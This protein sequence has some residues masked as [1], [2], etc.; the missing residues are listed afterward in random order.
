MLLSRI[1]CSERNTTGPDY[2]QIAGYAPCRPGRGQKG[3]GGEKRWVSQVSQKTLWKFPASS[4]H[5]ASNQ[6][7]SAETAR[8]AGFVARGIDGAQNDFAKGETR[9]ADRNRAA[10]RITCPTATT[11]TVSDKKAGEGNFRCRPPAAFT[12]LPFGR[13]DHGCTKERDTRFD[14]GSCRFGK[15]ADGFQR[16]GAS[17][18]QQA[19]IRC[20]D[21]GGF[22][23]RASNSQRHG[24]DALCGRIHGQTHQRYQAGIQGSRR[25]RW[26]AVGASSYAQTFGNLMAYGRWIFGRSDFRFDGN[27]SANRAQNLSAFFTGLSETCGGFIGENSEFYKPV[28]KTSQIANTHK[29]EKPAKKWLI[30][31]DYEWWS[32][33]ESNSR[34][35]HCE[36]RA[37]PTELRP[38]HHGFC[39]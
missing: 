31:H 18:Q 12:G 11:R 20:P 33:G 1:Y 35:R 29:H 24:A 16:S 23:R 38:L 27:Q 30:S 8:R 28:C 10:Y 25:S 7:L 15:A 14:M 37:L 3:S 17:H 6:F 39:P 36:R 4:G 2:I 19:A 5:P 22:G 21:S 9:W 34:P 26:R 13:H 32:R